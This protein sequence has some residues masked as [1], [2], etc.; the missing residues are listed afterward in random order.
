MDLQLLLR[1]F[2]FSPRVVTVT[3]KSPGSVQ[4][5]VIFRPMAVTPSPKVQVQE[6]TGSPF[7]STAERPIVWPAAPPECASIRI[8]GAAIAA[9]LSIYF[10][11]RTD[12]GGT[13]LD[14]AVRR[15]R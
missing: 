15:H 6:T 4:A 10:T 14:R 2:P 5:W 13:E 7:V 12:S 3:V 1:F 8:S 11:M 9:P